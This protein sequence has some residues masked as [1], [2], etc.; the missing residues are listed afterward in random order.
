MIDK[1]LLND[2]AGCESPETLLAAM[3]RHHPEPRTPVD[4]E[5][6]ARKVGIADFGERDDDGAPSGLII[7]PVT[8]SGIIEF[9]AGLPAPR[10]RYAIAHQLGHF[11]LGDHH[12]D[13][14]C[15]HRDL[16]ENRRDTTHRKQEMRANRFAAGL[17]MP[18]PWFSDF[19]VGLGKQSVLHLAAIAAEYG[20]SLD[21][22]ATRYAD[23]TQTMGAW[24]FAKDGT[25]RYARPSRSFPD[26]AIQAGAALP[27]A[28]LA[29]K[30]ED[31]IAWAPADPRDWIAVPRGSRPPKLAL[32]VH[33]KANGFQLILLSINAA[34]ERRADEE[35]EKAATESPKF[36]R[37]PSR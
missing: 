14:Q 13:R 3:L 10:R 27:A 23:L 25:F 28:L 16:A 8:N 34:A 4:V 22:A 2:L 33:S 24:L 19:V 31:R 11:L 36:G 7:D 37:R 6:W 9:A 30:P 17:L 1:A 12:G 20:V 26:L 21:V 32:Q 29:A 15:T 18:K 35:A 5:A